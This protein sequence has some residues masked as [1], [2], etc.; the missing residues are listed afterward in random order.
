MTE[1]IE[2]EKESLPQ[3]MACEDREVVRGTYQKK[4]KKRIVS[5]YCHG[6]EDIYELKG[7]E[8]GLE[9]VFIKLKDYGKTPSKKAGK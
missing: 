1:I 8:E 3:C 4:G 2:I 7:S 9:K 5:Y 6:E